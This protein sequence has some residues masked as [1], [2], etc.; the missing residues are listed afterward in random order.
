MFTTRAISSLTANSQGFLVLS[1]ATCVLLSVIAVGC[2]GTSQRPDKVAAPVDT[3]KTVRPT[4]PPDAAASYHFM[5]GYQAEMAQN[6]DRAI[7][8]YQTALK[9]DPASQIV[10]ARL[11]GLYFSLGDMPNA[12]RYADQAAEGPSQDSQLITQLA[13]ILASAGQGDR[14]VKLL[15]RAIEFDPTAADPYFTKGLLLMNMKR[16][17][18]A[19]LA[20]RSGLERAPES[21]V[22]HYHLGRMLLDAGKGEEAVASFERAIAANASFEP[23]YLALAS[24]YESR[25]AQDR[26]IAV[27]RKYLQSVNPRNRDIR[28]QL[29]RLYV[30]TKDYQGAR[31]ELSDLLAEDP[32]DLDAQLRLA[33]LYG[34]EKQYSKAIELLNQIL[35]ARPTELKIRDYLGFLYEE[36]KDTKKAIETYTFNVQLE[37]SYFEG[38]LHLGLLFYRLKQ[39][40]EAVTHLTKAITI[41]PKQPEAHIVLGLTY[42]QKDQFDDAAR[43]FEEGIAQNPKNADLYF[44]LGTVYDKLNRFDDVVR[45]ME[46]AI[47][48]D[49]HHADALNYLGY[50]YAERGI[51][52]DQALS[53]T[54]RAVALKP[55]NGYY[56]DSL[57]WALFKSGLY[58][59]ALTEMKRA[60]ALASD[61]P[62][63]YEHLGDIYAKQRDLSEAREAWLHALELDPSNS[64]LIERFR[65]L[66]MG[67]P[68]QEERIQQA[69][70]R[71]SE[72]IHAE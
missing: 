71:V 9:T 1:R 7:E 24:V 30:A 5:L 63:L 36:S 58:S 16:Q 56:V 17:P 64:K 22:G 33:L 32:S 54:K 68:T 2:A 28:H 38:H 31:K 14:A 37:P 13:G 45:V 18:E 15:D 21:S 47:K 46:A 40:P 10:K 62:V 4:H 12:V 42:L 23:A 3:P 69:K 70:Q 59:E 57:A 48:L 44:N 35:K 11:A 26:A 43:A 34:E 50:S 51:K 49:P 19:E 66:G 53:L 20:I 25:Q 6:T 52:I 8:E 29:V 65:E 39:G 72:K 55:S 60:V 67:D 27:L 61:D 41:N